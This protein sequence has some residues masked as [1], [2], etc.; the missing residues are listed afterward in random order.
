M[1]VGEVIE[2]WRYPVKSMLGE[3]ASE[4]RVDARGVAGDRAYAVRDPGG[5]LGSGKN[6]RRFR[7]IDGLFA[8]SAHLDEPRGLPVVAFGDG[9]TL[10]ADDP[11]IDAALSRALNEP[12]ALVREA[13]TSH[14]DAAPIHLV[15]TASLA[16]LSQKLPGVVIDVR[17]FRPNLLIRAGGDTPVEQGWTGRRL[18]IGANV[19][20]EI[21]EGAE[22]CRMV[23]LPQGDLAEEPDVLRVIAREADARFGVY[24]KVVTTGTI[25][26]HDAVV[27]AE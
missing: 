1:M 6:T 9:T 23:S 18:R 8:L 13:E 11:A 17:R 16:W 25:R 15:T 7:R 3:P 4:L 22:R 26:A 20:L 27:L 10:R 14:L 12:V 21:T 2:C 19:E 5:K 24:A